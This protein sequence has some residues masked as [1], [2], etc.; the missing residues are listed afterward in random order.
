MISKVL[1][2][3]MM[4][5]CLFGTSSLAAP[6]T[7]SLADSAGGDDSTMAELAVLS[8][9]LGATSNKAAPQAAQQQPVPDAA[10]VFV[11]TSSSGFI[12]YTT[13]K[14][15][16]WNYV[17]VPFVSTTSSNADIL[18]ACT[19]RNL[20][21]PCDA[22][23]GYGACQGCTIM[24]VSARSASCGNQHLSYGGYTPVANC[25]SN[26]PGGK[27]AWDRFMPDLHIMQNWNCGTR[28][29]K[30]C[31]NVAWYKCSNFAM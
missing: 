26:W 21:A 4:A 7:P 20:V 19:S 29:L 2:S 13:T 16:E 9:M 15:G 31:S 18:A 17:R 14:V 23:E 24:P 11:E 30:I 3:C 8:A 28:R 22:S 5:L 27:A 1:F 12:N 10:V 6:L 25:Y